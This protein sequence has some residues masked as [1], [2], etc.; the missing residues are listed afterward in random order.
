MFFFMKTVI[1]KNF[2]FLHFLLYLGQFLDYIGP[3]YHFG[4]LKVWSLSVCILISIIISN[5]VTM[6][7]K[8]SLIFLHQT[9]KICYIPIY[10]KCLKLLIEV[11]K[12]FECL[13]TYVTKN[14]AIFCWRNFNISFDGA[15]IQWAHDYW[16]WTF[17]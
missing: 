9:L 10:S 15:K 8:L 5:I 1:F 16:S 4:I 14:D 11:L 13:F 17:H 6:F 2:I 12:L 7:E 3:F